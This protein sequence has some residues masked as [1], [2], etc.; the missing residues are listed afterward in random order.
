LELEAEVNAHVSEVTEVVGTNGPRGC[1]GGSDY[2]PELVSRPNNNTCA[3]FTSI[4]I[5]V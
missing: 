5:C 1:V 3:I 4:A 2:K